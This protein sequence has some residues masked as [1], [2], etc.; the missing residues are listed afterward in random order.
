MLADF[1]LRKISNRVDD[2]MEH[3]VSKQKVHWERYEK[4]WHIPELVV[5]SVPPCKYAIP[6]TI[7]II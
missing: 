6:S 7:P 5:W 4:Y 2:A 1:N 3:A